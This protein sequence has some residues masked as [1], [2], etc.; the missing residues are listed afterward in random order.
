M[1]GHSETTYEE[2]RKQLS[3]DT[4]NALQENIELRTDKLNETLVKIYQRIRDNDKVRLGFIKT[5]GVTDLFTILKMENA[6][7][8]TL[9]IVIA[10]LEVTSKKSGQF[11]RTSVDSEELAGIARLLVKPSTTAWTKFTAAHTL[12]NLSKL[13]HHYARPMLDSGILFTLFQCLK[14]KNY[15]S[16]AAEQIKF[17]EFA[18]QTITNLRHTFLCK[19][20]LDIQHAGGIRI[21]T[22]LFLNSETALTVKAYI[23]QILSTL[24]NEKE[25]HEYFRVD[26][27]IHTLIQLLYHDDATQ[28]IKEQLATALGKFALHLPHYQREIDSLGGNEA[29]LTLL[30]SYDASPSLI[31]AVTGAFAQLTTDSRENQV[32]IL[33]AIPILIDLLTASTS[34]ID[35]KQ[36]VTK[37]LLNLTY[38]LRS[39]DSLLPALIQLIQDESSTRVTKDMSARLLWKLKLESYRKIIYAHPPE[40]LER[41]EAVGG[42]PTLLRLLQYKNNQA[43]Q[44]ATYALYHLARYSED[45]KKIILEN[46]G[47]SI[48]SNVLSTTKNTRT[49]GY[50]A[51]IL[52]LFS[53]TSEELNDPEL[54]ALILGALKPALEQH[55]ASFIEKEDAQEAID[56]LDNYHALHEEICKI[57]IQSLLTGELKHS[58]QR[59]KLKIVSAIVA[60]CTFIKEINSMKKEKHVLFP[61]SDAL[62]IFNYLSDYDD[63]LYYRYQNFIDT[64]EQHNKTL[65]ISTTPFAEAGA[66]SGFGG[67]TGRAKGDPEP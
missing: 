6:N 47:I 58:S 41:I 30:T 56:K 27:G 16:P 66:G 40:V 51:A 39:N 48:L 4:R 10:I 5:N 1:S 34:T 9:E 49:R 18:L 17:Q 11:G 31:E 8:S 32:A 54:K 36:H 59:D 50:S 44:F 25:D 28:K 12:Y 45:N 15:L 13:K 46:Q 3:L 60:S 24:L 37:I 42:I 67:P 35:T 29:L 14:N 52:T 63:E 38:H 7:S 43:Q 19:T 62:F 21:L 33:S 20:T 55:G 23:A 61:E 26:D 22:R 64:Y 65:E 2:Q 53:D 57:T